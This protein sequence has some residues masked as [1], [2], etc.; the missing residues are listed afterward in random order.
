[1]L[2]DQERMAA[3]LRNVSEIADHNSRIIQ[4]R[5]TV[6]INGGG[7]GVWIATVCCAVM[8]GIS[9]IGAAVIIDQGRR[10]SDLNDYLAA[11]YMQA[12]HLRPDSPDKEGA[13]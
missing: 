12:P 8:L 6:T 7:I 10:I 13:P 4:S 2:T 3:L 11:I 1:M 5:S 9:I